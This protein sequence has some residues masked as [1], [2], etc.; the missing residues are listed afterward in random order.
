MLNRLSRSV[1]TLLSLL[2]VA[3]HGSIN[4]AAEALNISQP[5]LTRSITRFEAMLGVPV[6]DR[7]A[8]GVSTTIFGEALLFH[9][10]AMEA[11]L[12]NTLRDV[13]ALKN[14]KRESLR[15]GATP[16]VA[17]HFLAAGLQ[18]ILIEHKSVPFRLIEGT[19]PQL[20]RQLGRGELDFVVSTVP[21]E[22]REPNLVQKPLF[23]L[24]LRVIVR[25]GHPLTEKSP[26]LLREMAH[27][28]WILPRADSGLYKR[29]V[30]DFRRAGVEFP[31]SVIETS[32]LE[33]TKSL[34]S[35]TDLI[36]ILPLRGVSEQI[37][38]GELV[39]LDGDW[40]FEHRTVGVFLREEETAS[41]ICQTFCRALAS[42]GD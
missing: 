8:R 2:K 29:V 27:Y 41:P 33:A 13:A 1:P 34:V 40:S 18:A 5:A 28:N 17:S 6:F 25:T 16:L 22:A 7:T 26:L 36:A 23:E 37:E 15:I 24:D 31:G 20:L 4:K 32:S 10:K 30:R 38:K 14:N 35:T 12:V 39:A 3:E 11:E 42:Q 9:A 21:F 19:R